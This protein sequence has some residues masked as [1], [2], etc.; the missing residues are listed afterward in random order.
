MSLEA[1][2]VLRSHRPP[3]TYTSISG[4]SQSGEQSIIIIVGDLL[5]VHSHTDDGDQLSTIGG[6]VSLSTDTFLVT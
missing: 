1:D 5:S 4:T 3:L 2:S 6:P